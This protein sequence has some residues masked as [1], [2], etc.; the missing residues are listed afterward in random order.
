MKKTIKEQDAD[1]RLDRWFKR[2]VPNVAHAMLE[3]A[4]RKGQVRLEGSKAEGKTRVQAGQSIEFPDEWAALKARSEKPAAQPISAKDAEMLKDC[5]IYKDSDLLAI[6]KPAGLAVQGGSGQKLHVDGMLDALRFGAD[7]RPRLVHRLD[8]DT[9]GVLLLARSAKAAHMLAARFSGKDIEKIY[10]ALT[11]GVPKPRQG[12]IELPLAKLAR[13]KSSREMVDVDEDGKPAVSDY[14][15]RE[16]LANKLALVE[17]KPI[18]GRTH[19]L[20]VHM[21]AI[22]HPI[23][24]DG[25]YGGAAAFIEGI[26]VS[27]QLHLHAEKII[28]PEWKGKTLTITADFPPHMKQSLRELGLEG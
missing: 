26:D 22:S 23:V 25:K 8:K 11:V 1:I 6:N 19:Q 13:G 27:R 17:L 2:H 7:E 28:L 5:V 20:R 16:A 15:V 4:L 9:S 10:V 24:G 3:K 12:R 14:R 18:T 21:A